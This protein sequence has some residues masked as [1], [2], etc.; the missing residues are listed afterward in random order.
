MT[1]RSIRERGSR[2]PSPNT[3]ATDGPTVLYATPR[4]RRRT[5]R[6]ELKLAYLRWK[7]VMTRRPK[8]QRF[9]THIFE[10]TACVQAILIGLSWLIDADIA[11]AKSP[12][13]SSM[14][15][16][17]YFWTIGYL[18]G[19]PMCIFGV[20]T[21]RQ[22]IRVG[23]LIL[24]GTAFMTQFIAGLTGTIEPRTFITGFWSLACYLRVYLLYQVQVKKKTFEI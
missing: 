14:G 20:I 22:N 13:G 6:I 21:R 7:T 17:H 11:G 19:A 5:L 3:W 8:S 15:G 2:G 1:L 18:V 24:L 10:I 16:W 12:I 9:L 23:G 4:S